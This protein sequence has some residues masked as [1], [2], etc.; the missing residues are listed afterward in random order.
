ML[1]KDTKTTGVNVIFYLAHL[2]VENGVFVMSVN[3]YKISK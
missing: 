2:K 3:V 1:A